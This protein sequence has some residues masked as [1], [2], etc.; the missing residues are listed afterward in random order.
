MSGQ[1]AFHKKAARHRAG[2]ARSSPATRQRPG[3]G[4]RSTTDRHAFPLRSKRYR[5][6]AVGVVSPAALSVSAALGS[7]GVLPDEQTLA[8]TWNRGICINHSSQTLND[9]VTFRI[10]RPYRNV[11][12][13]LPLCVSEAGVHA[14]KHAF[15]AGHADSF[16]RPTKRFGGVAMHRFLTVAAL[17]TVTLMLAACGTSDRP[18]D[19]AGGAAVKPETGAAI[20]VFGGV[21]AILGALIGAAVGG[22]TGYAPTKD[23]RSRQARL[24]V[25]LGRGLRRPAR[26][27]SRSISPSALPPTLRAAGLDGSEDLVP[28]LDRGRYGRMRRAPGCAQFVWCRA[29]GPAGSAG[30]AARRWP[31]RRCHWFHTWY[32]HRAQRLRRP[33]AW[34]HPTRRTAGPAQRRPHHR[35]GLMFLRLGERAVE[36]RRPAP[37]AR[38]RS[39]WS[40]EGW[41]V[42][43]AAA[44]IAGACGSKRRRRGPCRPPPALKGLRRFRGGGQIVRPMD[45]QEVQI[46]GADRLER[47]SRPSPRYGRGRSCSA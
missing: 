19:R 30:A 28:V 2:L 34:S 15:A 31:Q 32:P 12:K 7:G 45:Q 38:A 36:Q 16:K 18:V 46:V 11:F 39:G 35:G 40:R 44:R 23:R 47:S 24:A 8:R 1:R 17:G 3:R 26:L 42:S 4:S 5:P 10:V 33:G 41:R 29:P 43:T 22:G 20:G 6:E 25:T 13:L 27:I 14:A 21:G 9:A 37:E